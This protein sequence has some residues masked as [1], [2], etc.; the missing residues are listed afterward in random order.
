M[1][2]ESTFA[3]LSENLKTMLTQVTVKLQENDGRSNKIEELL[4]GLM[5]QNKI[6]EQENREINN[7]IVT[8]RGNI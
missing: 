5:N 1:N 3:R 7:R 4:L 8:L 2:A 6:M